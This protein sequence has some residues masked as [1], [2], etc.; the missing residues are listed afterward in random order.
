ML[1]VRAVVKFRG[2]TGK[3]Q[4]ADGAPADE[5]DEGVRGIGVGRDEHG[6]AGVLAVVE[7]EKETAAIVPTFLVVAAQSE[8]AAAQLRD[9]NEDAQKI[10]DGAE[11]FE[12]AIGQRCYVGRKSHT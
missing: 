4:T 12:V 5:F 1:D 7:G 3:A 8:G 9:A 10:A 2:H 6:A 11:G